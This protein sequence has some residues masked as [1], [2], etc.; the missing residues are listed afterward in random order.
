[1]HFHFPLL[2]TGDDKTYGKFSM[3]II[4]FKIRLIRMTTEVETTAFP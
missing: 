1:M 2:I 3:K 4:V